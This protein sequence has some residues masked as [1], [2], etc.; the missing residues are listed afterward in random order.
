M[1]PKEFKE[2]RASLGLSARQLGGA[3]TTDERT[4]KLNSND[5][6]MYL[7]FPHMGG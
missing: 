1:T 3:L 4:I 6:R 2:A 7:C 5:Q